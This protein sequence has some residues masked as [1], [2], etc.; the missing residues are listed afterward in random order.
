MLYFGLA[1]LANVDV[2]YQFSLPWFQDMFITCINPPVPVH[3]HARRPTMAAIGLLRLSGTI[4]PT[5]GQGLTP[6]LLTD[7]R[8]LSPTELKIHMRKM[9]DR[10]T[11]SIYRIVSV[12]LFADHQLMFSFQLCTSIMRVNS[13]YADIQNLGMIE[14]AEWTTF[15]QGPILASMMDEQSLIEHDGKS[16]CLCH[17]TNIPQL[18][19][20]YYMF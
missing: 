15:L 5:S 14:K 10:L 19:F 6:Q 3:D 18:I 11:S 9:I 7:T 1:D 12:A 2:M 13:K 16:H 20:Y 17:N 8:D 4:R